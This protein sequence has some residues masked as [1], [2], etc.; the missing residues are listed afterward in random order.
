VGADEKA[1]TRA[2]S[3]RNESCDP[4][5]SPAAATPGALDFCWHQV[6]TT[7]RLNPNRAGPNYLQTR[8]NLLP[9]TTRF[10]C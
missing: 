10:V 1:R 9:T 7:N 2:L 8:A 6:G 5:P 4:I 3:A